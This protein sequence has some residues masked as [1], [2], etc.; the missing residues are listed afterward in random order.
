MPSFSNCPLP[1][2]V[3]VAPEADLRPSVVASRQDDV[4]LV[5]AI[6]PVFGR[7]ER[8][9]DGM[10]RQPELVAMAHR[11][12]LGPVSRFA[13]KWIS[14]RRLAL[15]RETHDFAAQAVRLLRLARVR[16]RSCGP[17]DEAVTI[18]HEA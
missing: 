8:A 13:S 17:E 2:T 10:N 1:R 9:A 18:E 4:Q 5:A 14:R 15:V 11:V 12:D 16:R 3:V 7:P 6:R